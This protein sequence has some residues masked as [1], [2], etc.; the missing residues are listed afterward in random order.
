MTFALLFGLQLFGVLTIAVVNG[1]RVAAL[2]A[3]PAPQPPPASGRSASSL[4]MLSAE[5]MTILAVASVS[6]ALLA[7]AWLALLQTGARPIIFAGASVGTGLAFGNGVWLLATGGAA[8]YTMGLL[9]LALC[10]GCVAYILLNRRLLDFSSLLLS[11][12]ALILRAFPA[13]LAVAAAGAAAGVAWLLL[14]SAALASTLQLS[15]QGAPLGILLL[16]F[17]WTLQTIKAVVHAT[18]AGENTAGGL[19][20]R[21]S[22]VR[23]SK[24]GKEDTMGENVGGLPCHGGG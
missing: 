2:T 19:E 6:S 23:I 7:L 11:T 9:S 21:R 15:R 24:G 16:S 12:V 18:V 3:G 20:R 1:A 13:T 17:F 8:G 22:R 14:W 10:A 4:S 5:M